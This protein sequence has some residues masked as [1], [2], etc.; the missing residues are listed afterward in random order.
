MSIYLRDFKE[1]SIRI[2]NKV[3][4]SRFVPKNMKEL[5][6]EQIPEGSYILGVTYM[7]GD[8]QIGISGHPKGLETIEEGASRE[9]KEELSLVCKHK[10]R[11][12]YT[13]HIN[14][15]CFININDTLIKCNTRKNDLKDIKDRAVICVYGRERDILHYLA[16]VSY[17]L[18]NE[19]HIESIWSTSKENI[20]N[21]LDNK[22]SFLVSS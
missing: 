8:S 12:C 6:Q 4:I 1:N 20:I 3:K 19:D 7:T 16:N 21:Y 9:L 17:D 10:L 11:F 2:K 5:I 18:S 22:K 14:H 13:D 15:F